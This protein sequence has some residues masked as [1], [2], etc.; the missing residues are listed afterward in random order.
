MFLRNMDS[1]EGIHTTATSV[2]LHSETY[3]ELRHAEQHRRELRI[4]RY[5]YKIERRILTFL[6][7]FV[8]KLW[9]FG[10]IYDGKYYFC[11]IK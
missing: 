3:L 1:Y 5:V 4:C 8:E 7:S 10:S 6:L 2:V 9:S 11:D